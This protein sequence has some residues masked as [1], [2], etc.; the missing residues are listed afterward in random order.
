MKSFLRVLVFTIISLNFTQYLFDSFDFGNP[1]Y[2]LWLL[3]VLAITLLNYFVKM[4]LTL[5]SLPKDGLGFLI[6]NTVLTLIILYI[7]TIFMADLNIKNAYLPEL[8][9]F[10]FMLP[11]KHLDGIWSL[12]VSGVTLSL[13]YN[14]FD[15]LIAKK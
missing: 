13:V 6:I 11:S 5:V 8:L 4:V 3:V 9:I 7:L 14:F 15:W 12:V 10:G 2:K 1:F